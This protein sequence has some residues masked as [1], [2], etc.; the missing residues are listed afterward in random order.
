MS[1]LAPHKQNC[2]ASP[3][4]S[5]ITNNLGSSGEKIFLRNPRWCPFK[6]KKKIQRLN[7]ETLDINLH[8][9]QT[10]YFSLDNTF[11]QKNK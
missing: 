2:S 8:Y 9:F 1:D 5:H 6:I 11:K 4:L 3:I 7:T 10:P